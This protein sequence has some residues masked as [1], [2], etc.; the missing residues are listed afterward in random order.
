MEKWQKKALK[1]KI[2]RKSNKIFKTIDEHVRKFL[3]NPYKKN[4]L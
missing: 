4:D 1:E 3:I 2:K